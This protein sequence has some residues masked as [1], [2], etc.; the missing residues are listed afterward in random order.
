MVYVFLA[1]V[2]VSFFLMSFITY[3]EKDLKKFMQFSRKNISKTDA[4]YLFLQDSM[5]VD[6]YVVAV[7]EEYNGHKFVKDY[8]R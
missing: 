7:E 1:V 8:V 5:D 6:K 3:S 4:L 2:I